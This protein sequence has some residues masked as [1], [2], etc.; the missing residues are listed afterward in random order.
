M[1]LCRSRSRCRRSSNLLTGRL[2]KVP[3]SLARASPTPYVKATQLRRRHPTLRNS[4]V[5]QPKG[6]A[7]SPRRIL[8]RI[9]CGVRA[10]L[11]CQF[12]RRGTARRATFGGPTLRQ[13]LLVFP[14][15]PKVL[16]T[17]DAY[18]AALALVPL[19]LSEKGAPRVRHRGRFRTPHT[20]L[21]PV[22]R[23]LIRGAALHRST[24]TTWS[25]SLKD[26]TTHWL[27]QHDYGG[28]N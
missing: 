14:H 7:V 15:K 13:A 28:Q 26:S 4:P 21:G 27:G 25:V 6:N 2:T 18:H 3:A 24:G 22:L 11:L 16:C 1:I 20:F 23:V 12:S 17:P 10:R 9:K 19:L 5:V 8:V